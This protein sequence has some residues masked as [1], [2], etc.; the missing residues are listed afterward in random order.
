MQGLDRVVGSMPLLF[1]EFGVEAGTDD[2]MA[3]EA[4]EEMLPLIILENQGQPLH[5][6]SLVDHDGCVRLRNQLAL[7]G[8][9]ANKP[10]ISAS[11]LD[12]PKQSP[13]LQPFLSVRAF[14]AYFPVQCF[15]KD[16]DDIRILM[17]AHNRQVV[18]MK[19]SIRAAEAKLEEGKEE[20]RRVVAEKWAV[21]HGDVLLFAKQLQVAKVQY[22]DLVD[23]M[24]EYTEAVGVAPPIDPSVKEFLDV[25]VPRHE[26]PHKR[27]RLSEERQRTRT[28]AGTDVLAKWWHTACNLIAKMSFN[29]TIVFFSFSPSVYKT[30]F[31][32]YLME[33][34]E[35]NTVKINVNRL[36]QTSPDAC[37]EEISRQ[38]Y[39]ASRDGRYNP[40]ERAHLAFR[41]QRTNF[42]P[43]FF[44]TIPEKLNQLSSIT[45]D[46]TVT[47]PIKPGVFKCV[48]LSN[49]APTYA[50]YSKVAADCIKVVLVTHELDMFWVPRASP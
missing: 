37:V 46:G 49:D 44:F 13:I 43:D 7:L 16:E 4:C 1:K 31:I 34:P 50:H 11:S 25:L 17:E 32:F 20:A 10:W 5:F 36:S 41:F 15:E 28:C 8:S 19:E 29:E 40:N 2:A 26:P 30:Q 22:G 27:V 9:A 23:L 33:A 21:R 35:T 6:F 3:L 48:V 24:Q 14:E 45:N 18:L 38:L 12:P 39:H 42:L 47:I